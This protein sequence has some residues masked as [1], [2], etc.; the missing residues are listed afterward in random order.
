ML[1]SSITLKDETFSVNFDVF[2]SC[3]FINHIS[4]EYE[5]RNKG[6]AT[7]VLK[8]IQDKYNL[9]IFLLAFETLL[10]FYTKLNFSIVGIE[11]DDYFLMKWDLKHYDISTNQQSNQSRPKKNRIL[12]HSIRKK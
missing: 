8:Q 6:I 4:V 5:H 11:E 2:G 1:S 12:N 9:P 7:N 3:I 10:P